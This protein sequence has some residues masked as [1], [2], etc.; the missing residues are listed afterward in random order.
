M[1][2]VFRDLLDKIYFSGFAEQLK[3]E[4][5]DRYQWELAEFIKIYN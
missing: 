3:R 5:P 2:E 1:V 4:E